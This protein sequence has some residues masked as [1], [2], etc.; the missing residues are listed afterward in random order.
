MVFSKS[1]QTKIIVIC[2]LPAL[3][4]G[5]LLRKKVN[6]R[7]NFK[8]KHLKSKHFC[9]IN[10][11]LTMFLDDNDK[12]I[13]PKTLE[14]FKKQLVYYALSVEIRSIIIDLFEEEPSFTLQKKYIIRS[15]LSKLGTTV[16]NIKLHTKYIK[17]WLNE[18]SDEGESTD[19]RL[20]VYRDKYY[21]LKIS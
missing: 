7:T 21:E 9:P 19:K 14:K 2:E 5:E 17:R 20:Q 15:T 4:D 16:D 11:T 6:M 13:I 1:W 12:V 18:N 3:N 8:P 10:I